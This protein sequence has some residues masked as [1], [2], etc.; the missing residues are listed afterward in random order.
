VSTTASQ[1]ASGIRRRRWRLRLAY[2]IMAS[3]R[4]VP[5]VACVELD[6]NAALVESGLYRGDEKTRRL[7]VGL[8]VV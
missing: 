2:P 7:W 8:V 6:G 3:F 4:Y 1:R 5:Y